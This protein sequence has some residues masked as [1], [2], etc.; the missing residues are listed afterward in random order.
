[1]VEYLTGRMRKNPYPT[2]FVYCIALLS[3]SLCPLPVKGCDWPMVESA[4][5][6][7][8][9]TILELVDHLTDQS[10]DSN[11]SILIQGKIALFGACPPEEFVANFQR[12][13]FL[14][15]GAGTDS[16]LCNSIEDVGG[17]IVV[18]ERGGCNFFNKTI[19]AVKANASA[20]VIGDNLED[21]ENFLFPMG[22]PQ[23]YESLCSNVSIPSVLITSK[24]YQALKIK[25]ANSDLQSLRMRVFAR[26]HPKID[27]ASVIIWA[28][29]VSIVVI[30][31][32]LSAYK[33]RTTAAGNLIEESMEMDSEDKTLPIQE[34]NMSHALGFI[35]VS[36][37]P[38]MQQ[39]WKLCAAKVDL[40]RL[41]QTNLST[42][43]TLFLGIGMAG[44]ATGQ[45]HDWANGTDHDSPPE[46]IPMLL[47]VP[48][49]WAGGVTLLGLGDVV[50]PGLLVS[51]ALRVDY[52]KHKRIFSLHEHWLCNRTDACHSGFSCHAYGTASTALSCSM[53]A[54]ALSLAKLVTGY[55]RCR[56][57][58]TCSRS[59]GEL[60]EMWDGPFKPSEPDQNAASA[61]EGS[62][63]LDNPDLEQNAS[64]SVSGEEDYDTSGTTTAAQG[65]PECRQRLLD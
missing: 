57:T 54:L 2:Y 37:A 44:V 46:M 25:I 29:G 6:A 59:R 24:G 63:V 26:Q 7:T 61:A 35:V 22:C 19:N 47:V 30:A 17:A 8:P 38:L 36:S 40:W 27:P 21:S 52:L 51:F 15:D 23:E 33:E 11:E 60:K 13:V 12:V 5:A 16:Q 41:G 42:I 10:H 32:Y 48:K 64:R 3:A 65:L 34:L 4:D 53:H 43:C 9:D 28:M 56:T 45:G 58:D 62:N 31:S 20:I 18:A 50:L 14:K 49:D 1:M 39:A 55:S